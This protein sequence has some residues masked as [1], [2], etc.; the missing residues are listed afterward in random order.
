[1]KENTFGFHPTGLTHE[2]SHLRRGNAF[3][4]YLIE[5]F[6]SLNSSIHPFAFHLKFCRLV[7][8]AYS[9]PAALPEA[10]VADMSK[11]GS[12]PSKVLKSR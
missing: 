2:S 4:P 6:C 11:T 3:I 12:L 7:L 8:I 5:F 9:M 10:V 1:M